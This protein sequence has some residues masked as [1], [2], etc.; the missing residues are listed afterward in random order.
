MAKY[1]DVDYGPILELVGSWTGDQGTDI[2]PE[3]DRK[4]NNPY[5]ET[6]TYE[7][8]GELNNADKQE[9]AA[10]HYRQIVRRKSNDEVFHDQTGYWIWDAENKIVMHSFVI[11][12]AVSVVAGGIY[13]PFAKPAVSSLKNVIGS[14]AG[15]DHDAK[16]D[17]IRRYVNAGRRLCDFRKRS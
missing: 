9:L 17:C 8:L 15:E 1:P 12:R 14:E 6:I 7:D 13:S 16:L 4:E 11:P 10:V 5:Y 2:A 3:P